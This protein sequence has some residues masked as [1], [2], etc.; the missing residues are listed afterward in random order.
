VAA[1]STTSRDDRCEELDDQLEDLDDDDDDER[2]GPRRSLK[3]RIEDEM[4]ALDC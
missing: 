3:K 2:G 1:T 4:K